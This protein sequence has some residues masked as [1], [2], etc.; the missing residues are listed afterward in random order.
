MQLDERAGAVDRAADHDVLD[1][2]G[3]ADDARRLERARDAHVRAGVMREPGQLDA[4]ERGGAALRHVVAGD[5]VERRGLAA[6][7]RADQAVHFGGADGEI[8]AVDGAHAAEAQRDV[9][10]LHRA[11][12]GAWPEQALEQVGPRDDGAIAFQRPAVLEVEQLGDA[13][14]DQ[15]HDGEQQHRIKEGRPR[16]QRRGEFG[17]DGEQ[18]GAEQRSQHR[19]APADQ[20]RDEE[21][22]RKLDRERV[23]R[24]VG[25]QRREQPARDAGE[26][27][28]EQE[29]RDQQRRLGNAA[30][31]GGD[32]GIAD[33]GQRAAEPAAP[34]C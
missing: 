2:R 10:E 11:R 34:R 32:L 4:F 12:I 17:Q 16:D 3:F 7:V 25:L 29:D 18:D 30:G 28:G 33:R 27:A 31:L 15:Q 13:A 9:L 8:E 1:H 14:G 22:D 23:G 26:R 21:Q 24:D 19:A 6:A 20:H 5:H